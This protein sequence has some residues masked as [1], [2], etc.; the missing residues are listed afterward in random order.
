MSD[1]RCQAITS[2]FIRIHT[3]GTTVPSSSPCRCS[4]PQVVMA[5]LA[6]GAA[7]AASMAELGRNG[8]ARARWNPM[9]DRFGSFCRRGGAAL[10]SSFV[11]VALMLA[12]NLLSAASGAGC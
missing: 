6:T 8:N 12:L 3:H 2:R 1:D 5:L 7:A 10:A 11:G 9:C 4:G